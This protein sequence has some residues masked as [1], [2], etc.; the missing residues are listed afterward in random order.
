MTYNSLSTWIQLVTSGIDMWLLVN[1]KN[2]WIIILLKW[3]S[4][5]TKNFID[6]TK[7]FH[8]MVDNKTLVL[9]FLLHT[10]SWWFSWLK[11]WLKNSASLDY[12]DQTLLLQISIFLSIETVYYPLIAGNICLKILDTYIWWISRFPILST[13][14]FYPYLS[15]MLFFWERE[16]ACFFCFCK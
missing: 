9:I 8:Y 2:D 10:F 4:C 11:K 3:I 16:N 5:W 6:V 12:F 14:K 13:Y 7:I 1:F 15:K